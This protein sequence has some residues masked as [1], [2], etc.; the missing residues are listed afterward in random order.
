MTDLNAA[1]MIVGG[2]GRMTCGGGGRRIGGTV[3]CDRR[4]V[5]SV[6]C[7]QDN[8]LPPPGHKVCHPVRL[9]FE[10]FI[11]MLRLEHGQDNPQ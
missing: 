8:N 6:S 7:S 11:Q 5:T 1:A 3:T 2:G 4:S 10:L 9:R